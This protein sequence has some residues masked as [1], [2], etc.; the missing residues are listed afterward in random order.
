MALSNED[1]PPAWLR[2]YATIEADIGRMEEFAAKL[3]AEVRDNFTPHV[4]RIYDDMSV[5]LPEVYT[6]FPEL[7]SFVDAHQAS[8]LDTADLIYFYREATGAFAT[9]AGTVSAQYRDA[10]A[11]ATARVSDVKEALNATSAATPEA[12]W[13]PPDA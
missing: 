4:A 9:A 10:D 1:L 12:G 8:A 13:R 11:F 3:D 6:D 7:A 5:D 2:D